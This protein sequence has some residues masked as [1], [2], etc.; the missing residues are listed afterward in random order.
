MTRVSGDGAL[1]PGPDGK[2]VAV[3][4]A[5]TVQLLDAA[6]GLVRSLET[7]EGEVS[8]LAFTADG[9]TLV[10]LKA[11]VS[12]VRFWDAHSGDLKSTLE[13]PVNPRLLALAPSG[14]LLATSDQRTDPCC[15]LW[16]AELGQ[17]PATLPG[18][19]EAETRVVAFSG[20]GSVNSHGRQR[21]NR[22]AMGCRGHSR[23]RQR[24]EEQRTATVRTIETAGG[25]HLHRLRAGGRNVRRSCGKRSAAPLANAGRGPP[26]LT[27]QL[28][29]NGAFQKLQ[30]SAD[31]QLMLS[32]GRGIGCKV[33]DVHPTC[34]VMTCRIHGER[35]ATGQ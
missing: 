8:H 3:A 28:S 7:P 16:D 18:N 17:P 5:R 15:V 31:G 26:R 23:K 4:F 33:W 29:A 25:H 20:D 14:K 9:R 6:T 1:R 32:T 12:F 22:P 2:T 27:K 24:C 21:W 11:G 34:A 19:Q 35:S 30:F 10:T 13:L